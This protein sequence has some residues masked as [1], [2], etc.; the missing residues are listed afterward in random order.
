MSVRQILCRRGV[1]TSI[2]FSGM[3]YETGAVSRAPE[4][5]DS[6]DDDYG[7]KKKLK[8]KSIPKK[9]KKPSTSSLNA[10][11][12]AAVAASPAAT[13]ARKELEELGRGVRCGNSPRRAS[14]RGLLA[15]FL[16]GR[17]SMMV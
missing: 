7:A 16:G 3:L 11:A 9:A 6:D 12:E 8:K 1:V 15:S 4:L 13:T 5:T 17:P 14:G 10:K 2:F